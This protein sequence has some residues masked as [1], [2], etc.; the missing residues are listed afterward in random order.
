VAGIQSV[1]ETK[2]GQTDQTIHAWPTKI[3]T[4]SEILCGELKRNMSK[5]EWETYMKELPYEKTCK[6]LPE[7][8]K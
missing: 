8:E 1:K 5:D 2:V 6:D 3:T 4:M 7:G